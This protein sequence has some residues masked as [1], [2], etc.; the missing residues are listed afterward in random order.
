MITSFECF[1]L[2]T[3]LH[4]C[5]PKPFYKNSA[6]FYH[7]V[8]VTSLKWIFPFK[9]YCQLVNLKHRT[10]LCLA[11]L[12]SKRPFQR[13]SQGTCNLLTCWEKLNF[14]LG[15]SE[16]L[17]ILSLPLKWLSPNAIGAFDYQALFDAQKHEKMFSSFLLLCSEAR[18]KEINYY[19]I[20]G[21]LKNPLSFQKEGSIPCINL[22]CPMCQSSQVLK[23]QKLVRN[24]RERKSLNSRRRKSCCKKNSWKKSKNLRRSVCG[25]QWV[26][27]AFAGLF[28]LCLTTPAGV[29]Y[30]LLDSVLFY[31]SSQAKC[32]RS[33]HWT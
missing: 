30:P 4:H 24:K 26:S 18:R 5:C 31:R 33:I 28:I 1:P 7:Y 2:S 27:S 25:R 21:L 20:A 11:C 12:L 22:P 9:S 19:L 15:V 8:Y 17:N 13:L 16:T 10:F 32:Q 6:L 29:N 23:T 14:S 3:P